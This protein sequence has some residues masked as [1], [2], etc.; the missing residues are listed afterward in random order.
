MIP[1]TEWSSRDH[2]QKDKFQQFDDL[3]HRIEEAKFLGSAAASRLRRRYRASSYAIAV[4]ST[5]IIGIGLLP[6][7]T[8]NLNSFQ[9]GLIL[10]CS[11]ILPVLVIILSLTERSNEYYYQ[12]AN[13]EEFYKAMQLIEEK[14]LAIDLST[15]FQENLRKLSV[16]LQY[17]IARR[18]SEHEAVDSYRYL[19]ERF[20][21]PQSYYNGGKWHN[22]AK[23]YYIGFTVFLIEHRW[24][25]PHVAVCLLTLFLLIYCVVVPSM[26]PHNGTH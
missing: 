9:N 14:L 12:A 18:K 26:E 23:R 1:M 8:T 7:L 16:E 10:S 3:R 17:D 2:A 11:I 4:F 25:F 22:R 5:Y 6:Q 20:P 15:E 21:L 13:L 24:L 19:H